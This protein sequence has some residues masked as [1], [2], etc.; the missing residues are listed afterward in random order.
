MLN[1]QYVCSVCG[2]L[3]HN[4]RTCGKT[5]PTRPQHPHRPPQPEPAGVDEAGTLADAIR[6]LGGDPPTVPTPTPETVPEEPLTA[7]QEPVVET[8]TAEDI[9]T[10][11]ML[12]SGKTG[13][14]HI[15]V[16]RVYGVP[17]KVAVV[18]WGK[19]DTTKL[20]GMLD[21]AVE[22]GTSARALKKFLNF[23]GVAAKKSLAEDERTK[24]AVLL[25][26]AKDP[27]VSVKKTLAE[28]K[29]L[30]SS[31]MTI[32]ASAQNYETRLALAY[33]R[34]AEEEVLTKMY[35]E[36][37]TRPKFNPHKKLNDWNSLCSVIAKNPNLSA[38][39]RQEMLD[40]DDRSKVSSVLKNPAV[41][42]EELNRVWQKQKT[43]RSFFLDRI[44]CHPNTPPEILDDF[45]DEVLFSSSPATSV[46]RQ[47][48][49]SVCQHPNMSPATLDKAVRHVVSNPNSV[50]S[51]N[52]SYGVAR[53]D[54]T[55]D[56]TLRWMLRQKVLSSAV[57]FE[58][59][60][61]LQSRSL[62]D[63]SAIRHAEE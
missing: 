38:S 2:K 11:W 7:T 44:I 1:E 10:W 8:M 24:P 5:V 3:G 52:V 57:K 13:K 53:S 29:K 59:K 30:P 27:S 63:F 28:R 9:E 6:I 62:P 19:E 21:I 31:I 40:S 33:H 18:N 49:S 37:D 54:N 26:L 60:D 17:H 46:N 48:V 42:A 12:T 36:L 35:Q 22:Q 55:S 51:T 20:L 25:I 50:H 4:K 58:A 45:L 32:L 47:R 56:E 43:A 23:F 39:L 16:N 34:D 41:T 61:N 14:R 15:E